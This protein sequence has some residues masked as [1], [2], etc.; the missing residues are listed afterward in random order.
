M[1]NSRL[2]LKEKTQ[3]WIN[4]HFIEIDSSF[5][6]R[7]YSQREEK[8]ISIKLM[9]QIHLFDDLIEFL[10]LKR[11]IQMKRWNSLIEKLNSTNT[12]FIQNNQIEKNQLFSID[13][14]HSQFVDFIIF[15]TLKQ[16]IWWNSLNWLF[17]NNF[18]QKEKFLS[19]QLIFWSEEI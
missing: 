7:L 18:G 13:F 9:I 3:W 14:I 8:N 1:I 16:N 12:T 17:L 2:K 6:R 19:F 11:I 5:E 10:N 15:I 4:Y